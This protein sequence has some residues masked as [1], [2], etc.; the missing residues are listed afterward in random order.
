MAESKRGRKSQADYREQ[1]AKAL[2]S[3]RFT[4]EDF[5]V[6]SQLPAVQAW[7][8]AHP[9]EL[10]PHG[11]ALQGLLRQAVRDVFARIGDAEDRQLQRVADYLSSRY[12]CG[13]SVN[14]IAERWDCSRVHVWRVAGKYALELVTER[15]M[16][17]A[18]ESEK[19][20]QTLRVLE[21]RGKMGNI[22]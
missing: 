11:K 5:P 1:I 14:E 13:I 19:N 4:L 20:G 17:I 16:E 2:L 18:R 3:D 15:F 22:A 10:L 12:L 6:L 9:N 8:N 7:A 21:T